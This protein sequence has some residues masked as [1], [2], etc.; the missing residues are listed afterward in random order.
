LLINLY[1]RLMKN[2]QRSHND[3]SQ[4]VWS[5]QTYPKL[6]VSSITSK[7]NAFNEW[8]R[9]L[10]FTIFVEFVKTATAGNF[11]LPYWLAISLIMPKTPTPLARK[12]VDF[13]IAEFLAYPH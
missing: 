9:F 4:V 6:V 7:V 13:A 8:I 2:F 5:N 10:F 3:A 12:L 11:S 1:L